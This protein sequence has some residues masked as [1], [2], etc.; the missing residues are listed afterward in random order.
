M[1]VLVRPITEAELAGGYLRLSEKQA[2]ELALPEYSGPVKLLFAGESTALNWDAR[3]HRLTGELITDGVALEAAIGSNLRWTRDGDD[4]ILEIATA[5]APSFPRPRGTFTQSNWQASPALAPPVPKPRAPRTKRTR[6]T[7]NRSRNRVQSDFDWFD[8]VGVSHDSRRALHKALETGGWDEPESFRLRMNG[9]RLACLGGFDELHSVAASKVQPMDHQIA[10]VSKALSVMRG[11]AILADEVGL[12]KTIEAGLILKELDLRGLASR[13]LIITPATLREQWKAELEEKFG[14][15]STVITSGYDSLSESRLV[16]SLELARNRVTELVKQPWDMIILD[17]AHRAAGPQ[18]TASRRL[19]EELDTRYR[20]FLTA[21]PVNNDLLEL[22]R[23]VSLLRPG[24]F[25]SQAEFTRKFVNSGDARSPRNAKDLRQLVSNVMI[26]TTRE[27][28]GLDQVARHPQDVPVHLSRDELSAYRLVV[29]LLREVLTAPHDRMRRDSLARALTQSPR[30]LYESAKLAAAQHQDARTRQVL[31]TLAQIAADCG[32]SSRQRAAI[33]LVRRWLA[34]SDKGRVIVFTQHTRVL[35][36]LMQVLAAEGIPSMPYHGRMTASKKRASLAAFRKDVRVLVSTDAGAEGLNL[37]HANAV[38]NYD[39]PWNPMRIEQ[40]IGR[41]HRLTQ[42]RDVHVANLYSEGTIDQ[43]VYRI[44]VDK[45]RMFEILFGQ[46]TTILGELEAPSQG[47][48]GGFEGQVKQALY[49]A[50]DATMCQRLEALARSAGAAQAR[51]QQQFQDQGGISSWLAPFRH[52]RTALEANHGELRPKSVAGV[53]QRSA[54]SRQFV[55]DWLTARGS[56]IERPTEDFLSARLPEQLQAALGTERLHLAFSPDSLYLHPEAELCLVGTPLFDELLAASA[57]HGDLL[58][59]TVDQAPIDALPSSLVPDH[60]AGWEFQGRYVKPVAVAGGTSHWLLADEDTRRGAEIRT[61]AWG[62]HRRDPAAH[63]PYSRAQ[64]GGAIHPVP[65]QLTD[66]ASCT[67]QFLA[68]AVPN[69]ETVRASWESDLVRIH[70]EEI[71]RRTDYHQR[72]L[73]TYESLSDRAEQ[74]LRR[75]QLQE[76]PRMRLRCDLLSVELVSA[77]TVEIEELWRGHGGAS[78]RVAGSYDARS[79]VISLRDQRGQRVRALAFCDQ[80]H[81]VDSE[82]LA[83]CS[84]CGQRACPMCPAPTRVTNRCALCSGQFCSRCQDPAF[85]CGLCERN[86]CS[87]C[88]DD[89]LCQTCLL[90]APATAAEVAALPDALALTGLRVAIGTDEQLTVIVAAG[91]QRREAILLDSRSSQVKRWFSLSA[92]EP[93]DLEIAVQFTRQNHLTGDFVF[94]AEQSPAGSPDIAAGALIV[95]LTRWTEETWSSPDLGISHPRPSEATSAGI[96]SPS[97]PQK[98]VL[99][100]L[101]PECEGAGTALRRSEVE[102][103]VAVWLDAEGVH[104][105]TA[106]GSTL[107]EKVDRWRTG[108]LDTGDILT[109]YGRGRPTITGCSATGWLAAQ[110]VRSRSELLLRIFPRPSLVGGPVSRDALEAALAAIATFVGPLRISCWLLPRE[111]LSGP[112]SREDN[113]L[114]LQQRQLAHAAPSSV[115]LIL[116]GD[117]PEVMVRWLGGLRVRKRAASNRTI[118]PSLIGQIPVGANGSKATVTLDVIEIAWPSPVPVTDTWKDDDPRAISVAGSW[119]PGD[120]G[121]VLHDSKKEPITTLGIC[122][123]RHPT[124]VL[125]ISQCGSCG[126]ATCAACPG[127]ERI[128]STC[129]VCGEPACGRCLPVVGR[130]CLLCGRA[131]CASCMA[132]GSLC[133]TCAGTGAKSLPYWDVPTVLWAKGLSVTHSADREFNVLRLVGGHRREVVVLGRRGVVEKWWTLAPS[134][135]DLLRRAFADLSGLGLTGDIHPRYEAIPHEPPKALDGLELSL[136]IEHI[137]RWRIEGVLVDTE[138]TP[139]PT[140]QAGPRAA[141]PTLE[142]ALAATTPNTSGAAVPCILESADRVARVLLTGEGLARHLTIGRETQSHL[143]RWTRLP[144]GTKALGPIWPGAE[145]KALASLEGGPKAM[146]AALGDSFRFLVVSNTRDVTVWD[147]DDVRQQAGEVAFGK[148]ATGAWV[149]RRR[150]TPV[151]TSIPWEVVQGLSRTPQLGAPTWL[152]RPLGSLQPGRQLVAEDGK[153]A[154]GDAEFAPPLPALHPRRELPASLLA[155]LDAIVPRKDPGTAW[156]LEVLLRQPYTVVTSQGLATGVLMVS[157]VGSAARFFSPDGLPIASPVICASGHAG[158]QEADQHCQYCRHIRCSRCAIRCW[159]CSLCG[160][161]LCTACSRSKHV[162]AAC[163]DLSKIGVFAKH[164]LVQRHPA[165][166]AGFTGRD[167]VH[168]VSLL[169]VGQ[170]VWRELIVRG[171]PVQTS[172]PVTRNAVLMRRFAKWVN[173]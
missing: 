164:K 35:A 47:E 162:C 55:I 109:R 5:T 93:E 25:R 123:R 121:V 107:E 21:T 86:C 27:Q 166:V 130:G 48:G 80:R 97:G 23:L 136:T 101:V 64:R 110:L 108:Q 20:L 91:S 42:T 14:L 84:G 54:E 89:G 156:P 126:R 45:L 74:S 4:L 148:A 102:K 159:A 22:Y 57:E 157:G 87:D 7:T 59:W 132:A 73:D 144:A 135:A 138:R 88:S 158:P 79:G 76:P 120:P 60:P 146:V 67:Q 167:E 170:T 145:P 12:G 103:V 46:I 6:K 18:A 50:D 134:G 37:Q 141:E 16:M 26:R 32:P 15:S 81:A 43:H 152:V 3:A 125:A 104:T 112:A 44:L 143:A 38:I 9:E 139:G 149:P 31:N 85:R 24:T 28:T 70:E 96:T 33:S 168:E 114:V 129:R 39:L 30:S 34:D 165:L 17:E 83:A 36:D 2:A 124:D 115:R 61:V 62:Q 172:V 92:V 29:Q 169:L 52:H 173:G 8:Q 154:R 65:L 41:V 49:A 171:Q 98:R 90:L 117:S 75:L 163:E 78:V 100:A 161:P 56:T 58:G 140:A 151:A 63:V 19:L 160:I 10:A 142:S 40:R 13:V 137:H 71:Q 122:T 94:G 119:V 131:A 105:W 147:V 82:A 111:P 69:L 72:Q 66:P 99:L 113:P 68:D 77:L 95:H 1:S 106:S 53:S 11:R 150:V 127:V 51:A 133:R 116:G 128:E 118:G 153:P 155:G